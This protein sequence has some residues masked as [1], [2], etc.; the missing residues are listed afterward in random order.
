MSKRPSSPTVESAPKRARQLD[1][2]PAL[3]PSLDS[4]LKSSPSAPPAPPPLLASSPPLHASS[5]TF[6]AFAL[7]FVP[8][9]TVCSQETLKK[10]AARAVRA[11]DVVRLVGA[12]L[13]ASDDGAFAN[14]ESRAPGRRAGK[15]RARE[16]DHR[17][18]AV[19]TLAL[20]EGKDGTSGEEDYQLLEASEDDGERFG[21]ERV[22]RT[23]RELGGV[24]VLCIVCRWFG[25][26]M[27]GPVRF[28]Y[29]ATVAHTS[30]KELVAM[31][32]RRELRA[33]LVGLDSEISDM[34]KTIA[35]P[36]PPE[37]GEKAPV[38]PSYDD[39]DD[40]ERLQRLV[41]AREL[42]QKSLEK[43]VG[44]AALEQSGAE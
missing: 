34:R 30:S 28:T 40:V 31:L 26:D 24:D 6:I 42:T 3:A 7:S 4:W 10:E 41:K 29:M 12:E 16:P 39:I 9:P 36:K 23:L 35:G 19:R 1:A 17:T 11:L 32:T 15:E 18:W 38:P 33:V 27:L 2:A 14:G 22:L 21:G 43:R 20:A 44:C 8:P 25:G 37:E 13:L 5:S